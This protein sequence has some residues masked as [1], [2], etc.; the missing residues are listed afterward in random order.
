MKSLHFI[1]PA[2]AA[3]SL[4]S[5]PPGYSQSLQ[6]ITTYATHFPGSNNSFFLSEWNENT[7][8]R[9]Y[10]YMYRGGDWKERVLRVKE[11]ESGAVYFPIQLLANG[12]KVGGRYM[13][14][15]QEI[16]NTS[17]RPRWAVCTKQGWASGEE[18]ASP[19]FHN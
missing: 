19:V 9:D 10:F 13:C 16:L 4:L 7:S 6:G 14:S 8:E 18:G 3:C 12:V 15:V 1:V 5:V 2:L 17:P 11:F